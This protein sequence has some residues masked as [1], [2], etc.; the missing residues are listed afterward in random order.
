MDAWAN[1]RPTGCDSCW[2]CPYEDDDWYYYYY[3]DDDRNDQIYRNDDWQSLIDDYYVDEDARKSSSSD[4]KIVIGF[5]VAAALVFVVGCGI[6][7]ACVFFPGCPC[8]GQQT[9]KTEDT[10]TDALFREDVELPGPAVNSSNDRP[11]LQSTTVVHDE[12]K[13]SK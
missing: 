5:S 8:Y 13:S 11:A 6:I 4:T 12:S 3:Y 10:T 9:G 1:E 7:V 2:G